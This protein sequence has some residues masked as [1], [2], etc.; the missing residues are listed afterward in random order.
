MKN[1]EEGGKI[2]GRKKTKVALKI[3]R[4]KDTVM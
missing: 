3:P 1:M 4:L 2:R